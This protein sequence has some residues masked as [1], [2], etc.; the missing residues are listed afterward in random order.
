MD[1]RSVCA[2]MAGLLA[3]G[4]YSQAQVVRE[5]ACPKHAVDIAS[6]ATCDGDRPASSQT[7]DLQSSLIPEARVPQHKQTSLGLYID[8]GDAYRLK[9]SHPRRV[10]LVD[11]RSQ[12]EIVIAGRAPAADIHVPYLEHT[13]YRNESGRGWTIAENG[14]FLDEL[15]QRLEQHNAE[16]TTVILVMSRSGERSA[17]VVDQLAGYGYLLAVNVIDGFEGDIGADG[18]RSVNGWKNAGLPWSQDTHATATGYVEVSSP[19]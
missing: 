18:R 13:L 1:K 10:V 19:N 15:V 7:F 3:L 16:I 11:V 5:D 8:A 14:G 17:K 2:V 4:S 9:T 6:Y 12:L